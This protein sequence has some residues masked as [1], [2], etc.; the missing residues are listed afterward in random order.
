MNKIPNLL[1]SQFA[2]VKARRELIAKYGESNT[3]FTGENAEGEMVTMSIDKENGIVLKT[4]QTNGWV[5]VNY[6]NKDGV[7]EGETFEGK[8]R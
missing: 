6:Y 3:M 1:T 5:R 8:W 4:Y 7:A 2:D